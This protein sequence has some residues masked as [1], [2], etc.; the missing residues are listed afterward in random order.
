[1]RKTLKISTRRNRSDHNGAEE[2]NKQHQS[3]DRLAVVS[4]EA[5][6]ACRLVRPTYM[7]CRGRWKATRAVQKLVLGDDERTNVC[8]IEGVKV[9]KRIFII[10]ILT[11]F[12]TRIFIHTSASLFMLRFS[13][14]LQKRRGAAN[15][16]DALCS[17][18]T[19][20]DHQWTSNSTL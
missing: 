10:V 9:H 4:L 12:F 6:V 8:L 14:S 18:R 2:R 17:C 7:S 19:A 11:N 1:M 3:I 5:G 20:A 13:L 15:V 16:Q